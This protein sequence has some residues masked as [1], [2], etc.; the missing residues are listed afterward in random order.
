[1]APRDCV[2]YGLLPD[3]RVDCDDAK[4]LRC[5]DNGN[6]SHNYIW[7]MPC[8]VWASV[9]H[10]T[11]ESHRENYLAYPS[12]SGRRT[13]SHPEIEAKMNR[14]EYCQEH[15]LVGFAYR[16]DL[17][18]AVK[19]G[20]EHCVICNTPATLLHM[21][22][23]Q[24]VRRIES[25]AWFTNLYGA[26]ASFSNACWTCRDDAEKP[27]HGVW[28]VQCNLCGK[29][30]TWSHIRSPEHQTQKQVAIEKGRHPCTYVCGYARLREQYLGGPGTGS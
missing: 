2:G 6:R 4:F 24:H 11:T 20:S 30:A 17:L 15:L 10:C 9:S 23:T 22:T 29:E 5:L 25:S 19:D 21:A 3:G 14:S 16:A 1:M 18:I 26:P 12:D 7:C 13:I 28:N 8:G 27:T